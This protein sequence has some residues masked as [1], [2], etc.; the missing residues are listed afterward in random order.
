M[1]L[2]CTILASP[3]AQFQKSNPPVQQDQSA[4]ERL[5]N[6]TTP[7]KLIDDFFTLDNQKY[8]VAQVVKNAL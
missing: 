1:A 7:D 6:G 2:R 4:W 5:R 3:M 8:N